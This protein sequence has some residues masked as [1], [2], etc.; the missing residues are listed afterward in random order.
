ML[1]HFTMNGKAVIMNEKLVQHAYNVNVHGI[2]YETA[3]LTIWNPLSRQDVSDFAN[4][5]F[6]KARFATLVKPENATAEVM[7]PLPG[8][9]HEQARGLQ[10]DDLLPDQHIWAEHW[11]HGPEPFVVAPYVRPSEKYATRCFKVLSAVFLLVFSYTFV[12]L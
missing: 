12:L 1:G 8:M 5:R 11:Q 6:S 3:D 2:M 4:M 9:E 10:R 7:L